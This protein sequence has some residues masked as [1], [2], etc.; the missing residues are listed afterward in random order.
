MWNVM[1]D[2]I[3]SRQRWAR[4]ALLFGLWTALGMFFATKTY[5]VQFSVGRGFA[6]SK[7]LW[8]NL[9]EWYAWAALSP[10]IFTICRRLEEIVNAKLWGRAFTAHVTAG[11]ILAL[12][13]GAILTT[14]AR[15]EAVFIE[16]GF[17]WADLA[18]LVL[19]NHFHADFF[20]Y[21]AIAGVWHAVK[22]HN[23]FR[24]RELR[25][26]ELEAI[27][28]QAQLHALKM[29]LQPHFLFNTLQTIA[30]LVH[31]DPKL[32]D[33]MILRLSELL[34]I[35]LQ[36]DGAHEVSLKQEIDFLKGYL[37]IEQ[38]RMGDRLS[39]KL[40]IEPETWSA[41][42]PNLLL[43]PLVENAV[44]HGIAPFS[45]KGQITISSA[46]ANGTLR[47]LVK[48]S[49][50]GQLP[51]ESRRVGVGL[52]NTRARLLKLYGISSRMEL[53]HDDGF[54]VSIE[55]PFALAEP[56]SVVIT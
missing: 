27:L 17:D 36:S 4:R 18:W 1:I 31:Q 39:V 11:I 52:A 10:L 44:R 35:T 33:R 2:A 26:A 49:G 56:E 41:R 42:V 25:A 34:R 7:A 24:E 40:M 13:H 8:W 53:S 37:E 20:S 23:K 14:G 19:R 32:A 30:E 38:A 6:W 54:V 51:T 50:P 45:A 28:S 29:Q 22:F 5:Y 55:L 16:S 43:Q 12:L 9:M 46:R 3:P 48:D 21:L 47:L 15:I